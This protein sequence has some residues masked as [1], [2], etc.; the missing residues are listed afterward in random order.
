MFNRKKNNEQSN[1]SEF[2][3]KKTRLFHSKVTHALYRNHEHYFS[4]RDVLNSHLDTRCKV[5]GIRLSEYR[6]Q[7]K[8]EKKNTLIVLDRK[9][10]TGKPSASLR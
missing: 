3:E 6:A 1:F 7:R 4:K 5:C 2:V 8:F 10:K 9:M